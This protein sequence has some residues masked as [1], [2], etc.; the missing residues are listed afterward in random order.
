MADFKIS[1]IRFTWKGP[2]SGTTSY[3][4]DDVIRYNDKTYTCDVTHTSAVDFY[5]DLNA[6]TPKWTLT[7][8]GQAWKGDWANATF[9]K[10]GDVVKWG[11]LVY[12]CNTQHT[13]Q[14]YLEQDQAK[15]TVYAKTEDWKGAWTT[16]TYYKVND[17]VKYGATFYRCIVQHSSAANINLGLETDQANPQSVYGETK[18]QGEEAVRQYKK[19]IILRTSWVF[20]SH[21]QNFLKT[22]MKL[23]QEKTSLNV[24]SDQI[25]TPT[26]SE[27]L[28]DLTYHIIKTMFND[29][30]FKDFGTYHMTLED[31]TNWYH[32]AFLVTDEAMRLGLKT[33][34]SSKDIRP[35][36]SDLYPTL[37]RRPL[38]SRLDTTKI[39]KIFMLE[40]PHWEVE[41]KRILKALIH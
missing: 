19:H 23:I 31:E 36:S 16:G 34:M 13:S 7:I 3:V 18:W 40:L 41:V 1:N 8:D 38:N 37:A 2:W 24:V 17:V 10:L 35:I 20:S 33:L 12:N 28:A 25:G 21:G 15:W 30:N 27:A 6:A 39:K 4:K 22:I 5:T 29:P 9:Y 14:T 32:Y 26:S 11:G